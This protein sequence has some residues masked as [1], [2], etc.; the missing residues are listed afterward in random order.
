VLSSEQITRLNSICDRLDTFRR[1][2]DISK[3]A[4]ELGALDNAVAEA[5]PNERGATAFEYG[6][7][8]IKAVLVALLLRTFVVE[9]FKIP[10]GS[11]IPTLEIGDHLFV[12]KFIYGVR[13]PWTRKKIFAKEPRRG[14]V[15][16]FIFPK[17][18]DQEYKRK[19]AAF[20][21][22]VAKQ[23]KDKDFIKRVIAIGGDTVRLEDN[24][25]FVN[26]E[27]IQR[28]G[29]AGACEYE[30]LK[31]ALANDWEKRDCNCYMEKNGKNTYR[32]IQN[33]QS[34]FYGSPAGDMPERTIPEGTVFVMG[35][36]RDNSHDSRYWGTVPIN[37]IKGKA[38]FTWF[39]RRAPEQFKFS[40][41]FEGIRW[42]RFFN[43]I[44]GLKTS[45]RVVHD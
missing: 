24:Q 28:Q 21:E 7:S 20:G 26:N 11:M 9:A 4:E 22:D 32:V 45:E 34:E 13:I 30:D 38:M 44:H 41:I 25:V 40:R 31:G 36:N 5:L 33:S 12:N 37:Y 27:A 8:I 15:I 35:D 43:R 18:Q 1:Q 10:S 19:V 23:M 6:S 42:N 2:S 39:S 14:D 29:L 16:V 17:E 3:V